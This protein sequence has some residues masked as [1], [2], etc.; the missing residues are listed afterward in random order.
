MRGMKHPMNAPAA[1]LL[2]ILTAFNAASADAFFSIFSPKKAEEKRNEAAAPKKKPMGLT[3]SGAY[4]LALKRS[5]DIAMKQEVIHEAEAHFYQALS[6]VLPKASFVMTRFEQDAPQESGSAFEGASGNALRRTRPERRFIFSQPLFSGFKEFAA[7]QASGAERSQRFFEKR[8]AEELLFL[9]VTD[10]F[11]ALARSKRDMDIL[12]DIRRALDQR[13]KELEGRARIGRSRESEVMTALSDLKLV[14]YELQVT[15]RLWIIWEQLLEFYIG[16]PLEGEL[17][18]EPLENEPSEISYYLG[19]A[20]GRSDVKA[21]EQ[22]AIL[23][24]K[25]VVVAQ[26]GLF[27]TARLDGNA[28][29]ERVGFQSGID[30]DVLLTI[31]VPLFDGAETFGNIKEA[32]A[33]REGARLDFE[34][35]RRQAELEVKNTYEELVS[36]RLEEKALADAAEA[37]R[38][39]Y[40]LQNEEYRLNLVSNLEVLEAL[41][42]YQVVRHRLNGAQYEARKRFWKLKVASGL[43]LPEVGT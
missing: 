21:G 4:R 22:A 29:T 32:A 39:S 25:N 26:S 16:K 18:E 19:A 34:K 37:S 24:Q 12:N 5:E 10:A 14:E 38:K 36:S 33:K 2:L 41:R 13:I 11:Y 1:V 3:L 35:R 7:L 17:A 23:A 8:R 27:P 28:Y 9:D 30:W 42:Q 20:A 15:Q 43:A 31:D 6:I 40:E